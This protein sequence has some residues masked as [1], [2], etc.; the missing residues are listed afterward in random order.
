V[1]S[2]G[3]YRPWLGIELHCRTRD[4][5]ALYGLLTPPSEGGTFNNSNDTD[6]WNPVPHNPAGPKGKPGLLQ[7][8]A[9][10]SLL[11]RTACP[12]I[13]GVVVD[14]F[15][16]NYPPGDPHGPTA[17]GQCPACCRSN[18]CGE[19]V[20]PADRP[21]V[22]GHN[23]TGLFCCKWKAPVKGHC[24]PPDGVVQPDH[25]A[26]CLCPGSD[27]GCQGEA[28]CPDPRGSQKV[29]C[30]LG[31]N[32]LRL[33]QMRDLKAA[34][35]GKSVS[36]AGVVDHSSPVSAAGGLPAASLQSFGSVLL[37]RQLTRM[38]RGIHAICRRSRLG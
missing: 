36:A 26:C 32:Q 2:E 22:Y 5:N 9:R 7:G 31:G 11:A 25:P 13:A 21:H 16:S 3:L 35:L 4:I 34:L 19:A 18:A 30:T 15:W 33:A 6:A 10:W 23:A 37:S 1:A 28:L 24:A 20:C 12:Q 38:V 14:D 8:A 27:M 29:S 17:E